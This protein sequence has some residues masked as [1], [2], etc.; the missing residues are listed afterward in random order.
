MCQL[1]LDIPEEVLYD[2]R[3]SKPEAQSEIKKIVALQFYTVHRVSLGY[4]ASIA[5]MEKED[6][7]RY[8]GANKVSIYRFDDK[9]EFI[10]E[11]QNA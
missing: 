3:M 8:L 1:A 2:M 4:C 11:M 10:E 7:I 9:D 5:G 6:F